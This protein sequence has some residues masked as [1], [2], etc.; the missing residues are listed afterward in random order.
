MAPDE[1]TVPVALQM[2]EQARQAEEPLGHCPETGKPVYLKLGRF[3]PYVQRGS[4]DDEEKPKNAS[5]LKGMQ[6]ADVTLEL[7]LKLLSLPRELGN[8]P[9][10]GKPVVAYNGRFG[11]YIK[12]GDDTRSLPAGQ[13]PL[14]VTLEQ[15]VTLLAQPK[16]ARRGFG[17]VKEPLKTFDES[18]VTKQKVQL[19]DGRYGPYLTDGETN[20]SLPKD[21]SPD[22]LTHGQALAI[23]AERAAQGP[24]K[25]KSRRGAARKS[26]KAKEPVETPPKTIKVAKAVKTAKKRA[27]KRKSAKKKGA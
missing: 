18:P 21:V 7:A 4:L 26:A 19:L 2:L 12:S 23:L 16:A 27:P 8:H 5:L 10:T 9:E 24:P 13:S 22:E 14:D 11:P 25:K 15:A 6:P 1:V 20:A 17:R 3:G